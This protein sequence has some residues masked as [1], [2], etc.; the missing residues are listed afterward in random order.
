M[1]GTLVFSCDSCHDEATCLESRERGDSLTSPAL[2]CVCKD[3]FVGDGLSCYNAKCSAVTLLAVAKVITGHQTVAVWTLTSVPFQTHHACHPRFAKTPQ[4]LSNVWSLPPAQDRAPPLN[5]SSSTVETQFVLQAWTASVKMG[6]SV[7]LTPVSTTLYW[8]TTGVQRITHQI[9]SFTVTEMLTG[10]ASIACY[11]G[12]P[13]LIFQR[14]V[15][16]K[17]GVEPMLLC[18]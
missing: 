14:G 4:A 15:Y 17:T 5:M 16:L 1:T 10:K 13:V 2:S 11:C 9:Q 6:F 7:V 12:K 8:M 3:G 18:G